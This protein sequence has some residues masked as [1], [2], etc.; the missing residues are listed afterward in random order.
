MNS[1]RERFMNEI[2]CGVDGARL[3]V[4]AVQLP[5]GA[6]ETITNTAFIPDKLGYLMNAYD[7]QFRLKANPSVK[8]VGYM[9]V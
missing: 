5:T 1:L 7:E 2:N 8:I 9:I 3:I 6:I 4:T